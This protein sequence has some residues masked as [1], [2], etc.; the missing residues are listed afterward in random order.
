MVAGA[1]ITDLWTITFMGKEK[2]HK[3]PSGRLIESLKM[4][5][6]A[7]YISSHRLLSGRPSNQTI[8]TSIDGNH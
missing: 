3:Q 6:L 4:F 1:W 5:W 2:L 7:S 8:R